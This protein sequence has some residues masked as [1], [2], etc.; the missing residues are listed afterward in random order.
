MVENIGIKIQLP[1][2]L[3]NPQ[4]KRKI[5]PSLPVCLFI[6]SMKKIVNC[7]FVCYL[8]LVSIL[9]SEKNNTN[10]RFYSERFHRIAK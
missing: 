10:E 4:L 3:K 2:V 5:L 7:F 6:F 8:F 1:D 9:Q